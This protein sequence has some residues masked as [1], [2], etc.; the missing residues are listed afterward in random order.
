M[1]RK[2]FVD[3]EILS[4]SD[5]NTYLSEQSLMVFANS[6]ARAAAIPTPI[7]GLITYL[8]DTNAFEYWN[9]SSYVQV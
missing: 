3:G 6:T 7:E 9:G 2:V 4:A 5:M 8:S 1:P